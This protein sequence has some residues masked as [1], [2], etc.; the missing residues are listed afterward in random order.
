MKADSAIHVDPS[1]VCIV[2]ARSAFDHL[3]LSL[4]SSRTLRHPPEHADL[5]C[6]IPLGGLWQ[7]D[8][9]CID[10]RHGNSVTLLLKFLK[11]GQLSVDEDKELAERRQFLEVH[12][13]SLHPHRQHEDK[14]SRPV[15]WAQRCVVRCQETRPLHSELEANWSM[16]RLQSQF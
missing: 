5:T 11:T 8:R 10:Q 14:N 15:E 12:C 2:D 1:T 7:Y 6:Q 4:N 13:R 3:S 9:R 16:P